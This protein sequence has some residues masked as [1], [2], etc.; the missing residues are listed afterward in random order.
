MESDDVVTPTFLMEVFNRFFSRTFEKDPKY[1]LF[2]KE[3]ESF[4]EI[5]GK[6]PLD[7]DQVFTYI[8][9]VQLNLGMITVIIFTY[10]VRPSHKD[11]KPIFKRE[12]LSSSQWSHQFNPRRTKYFFR[13]FTSF[14]SRNRLEE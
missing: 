10:R 11:L 6:D 2:Q 3:W 9:K 8:A 14:G 4:K 13:F 5:L 12:F 7:L 1:P